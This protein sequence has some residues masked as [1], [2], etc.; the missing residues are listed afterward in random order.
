MEKLEA[1]DE[2]IT[3]LGEH[4]EREKALILQQIEDRGRE[5]AEMLNKFKVKSFFLSFF[6]SWILIYEKRLIVYF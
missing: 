6:L 2:R 5:L 4:F 1:L 3:Q